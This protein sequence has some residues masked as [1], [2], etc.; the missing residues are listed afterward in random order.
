MKFI[1]I[2]VKRISSFLILIFIINPATI[3]AQNLKPEDL[4]LRKKDLM[5]QFEFCL[6]AKLGTNAMVE[7]EE[8]SSCISLGMG[9]SDLRIITYEDGLSYFYNERL[10]IL[11]TVR[12]GGLP[13]PMQGVSAMKAKLYNLKNDMGEKDDM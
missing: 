7:I 5:K 13:H 1:N 9:Q 10:W 2:N 3:N 11:V 8:A 12:G 4:D 6:D